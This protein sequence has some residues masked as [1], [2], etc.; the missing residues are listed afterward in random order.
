MHPVQKQIYRS[1]TA[2]QKLQA[3]LRLYRSARQLK[4]AAIRLEHP[5]WNEKE[6]QEKVREIFVN[7]RT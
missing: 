1:M 7:A 6:V 4:T 2:E 5:D 3:A